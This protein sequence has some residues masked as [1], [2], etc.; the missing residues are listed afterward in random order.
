LARA[1]RTRYSPYIK[2]QVR[3]RYHL[4][5]TTADKQILADELGIGS[6]SKLYNLASRLGATAEESGVEESGKQFI[7][8]NPKTTKFTRD[9]DRYLKDEFGRREIEKIAYHLGH[10]ETAIF[11]RARHLGLRLPVKYWRLDKVATW[12]DRTPD[13]IKEWKEEGLDIHPLG[14][15][16]RELV[17]E[18]ISTTSLGRWMQEKG[19]MKRLRE[20]HD[21][22]EFFVLEIKETI[23]DLMNQ[24]TQFER[25]KFLSHG[26]VCQNPFTQNSYGLFCTNNEKYR[27]GEDP[28]CSVRT[29]AIEDLDPEEKVDRPL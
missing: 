14:N 20:G 13:E 10:S 15:R 25:C 21:I 1:Q 11:Y 17:I 12:L 19:N 18:V 29:L 9:A 8:E 5:R 4:C 26:H 2:E 6:V 22:D 16:N 3:K 28:R 27:A 7:K 23:K 24:E